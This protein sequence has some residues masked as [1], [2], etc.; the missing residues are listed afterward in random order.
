MSYQY[1]YANRPPPDVD[2]VSGMSGRGLYV[3]YKGKFLI[4]SFIVFAISAVLGMA[5]LIETAT[6][7][8]NLKNILKI[9]FETELVKLDGQTV[10]NYLTF[11]FATT[12]A[13]AGSMTAIAIANASFQA[14][15]R[16]IKQQ[17]WALAF[18][19]ESLAYA[20]MASPSGEKRHERKVRI[21]ELLHAYSLLRTTSNVCD[22]ASLSR[23]HSIAIELR[24]TVLT[25]ILDYQ[26][27]DYIKK[28]EGSVAGKQ[29]PGNAEIARRF[30]DQGG[31]VRGGFD[32]DIATAEPWARVLEINNS[33]AIVVFAFREI[34]QNF[35]ISN[36]EQVSGFTSKIEIILDQL[37]SHIIPSLF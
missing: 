5:M 3:S 13:F 21:D 8:P 17:E 12:V 7:L 27:L 19:E 16:A 9:Q 31:S 22:L 4:L 14:Q 30:I 23:C 26:V 34:H 29:L 25:A 28:P 33:V 20:D 37:E 35:D 10:A 11:A 6:G 32:A 1:K 15:E 18:Q 2:A 24:P 36:V